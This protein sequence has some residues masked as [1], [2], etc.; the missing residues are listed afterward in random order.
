MK[1]GP[2][3]HRVELGELPALATMEGLEPFTRGYLTLRRLPAVT[4]LAPLGQLEQGNLTLAG[5]GI[6]SLAGLDSLTR[7]G[8][9]IIGGCED[10]EAMPALE[11]IAGA[12]VLEEISELWVV[13]APLLTDLSAP[14]L[15]TVEEVNFVDTPALDDA[16]IAAFTAEVDAMRQCAGD[17]VE[18]SCL[19]LIPETVTHGCP[20]AW[21]DGSAVIGASEGGPLEGTTAFFGWR[22][23]NVGFA[24][25]VLVVL[26]ATSDVEAAKQDGIWGEDGGRPKA[27]LFTDSCY[28]WI[29]ESSPAAILYD[30]GGGMSEGIVELDVQGR[31]GNW[32]TSDPADPP[33]LHG[34]IKSSDPNAAVVLDGPF[35]AA[36][37]ENFVLYTGD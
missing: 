14:S 11:T 10:G 29:R 22:G 7:V 35:E 26:A 3:C 2:A 5:L 36:F 12:D 18:C 28:N 31:L 19:G 37:C 9:M 1:A 8:S 24:E 32:V 13:D 27:I 30:G 33:R 16:A 20:Q 4:D 21:S 25:L 6:A 34:T 15:A 23:G 17:I